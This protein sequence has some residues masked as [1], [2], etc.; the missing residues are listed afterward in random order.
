M[1][2]EIKSSKLYIIAPGDQ[3]VGI[4][5]SSWTLGP[6]MYFESKEH[7]EQFKDDILIAFEK[8]FG[9]EVYAKTQEEF[10]EIDKMCLELERAFNEGDFEDEPMTEEE[11]KREIEKDTSND[12]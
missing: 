1:D 2:K 7:L 3:S 9:D 8:A 6:E 11:F 5:P 12:K 4:F 10:D